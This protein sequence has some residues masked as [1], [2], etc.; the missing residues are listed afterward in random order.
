MPGE[1]GFHLSQADIAHPRARSLPAIRAGALGPDL[2]DDAPVAILLLPF[3]PNLTTEDHGR[4]RL[5]RA[6]AEGLILFGRIDAGEPHLPRLLGDIEHR[7]GVAVRDTDHSAE[8]RL[9]GS[10]ERQEGE[11][12]CRGPDP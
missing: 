11:K 6:L 2:A 1:A 12:D 4:K 8:E 10:S 5:L 7:D 9:G 3:D